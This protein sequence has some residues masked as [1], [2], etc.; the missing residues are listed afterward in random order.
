M[1]LHELETIYDALGLLS[2]KL[3]LVGDAKKIVDREIRLKRMN[4]TLSK[5]SDTY[6][7]P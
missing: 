4:P 5:E 7:V 3:A 6:S 1:T 2:N